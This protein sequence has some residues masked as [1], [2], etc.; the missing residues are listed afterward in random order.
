TGNFVMALVGGSRFGDFLRSD[1]GLGLLIL[2]M[3]AT[4]AQ[5]W[6]RRRQ[7]SLLQPYLAGWVF[8]AALLAMLPFDRSEYLTAMLGGAAGY[9]LVVGSSIRCPGAVSVDP[10]RV[11]CLDRHTATPGVSRDRHR[12]LARRG[13]RPPRLAIYGECRSDA[14]RDRDGGDGRSPL[15]GPPC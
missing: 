14:Q 12:F 15:H 1:I 9:D 3:I 8:V 2:L 4:L 11:I 10:A 5:A 13:I 7:F 6:D